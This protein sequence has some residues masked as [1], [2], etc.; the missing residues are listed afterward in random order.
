MGRP[1]QPDQRTTVKT[2][3]IDRAK[4]ITKPFAGDDH[5]DTWAARMLA[6]A[7]EFQTNRR[8][9]PLGSMF[10]TNSR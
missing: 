9:D 6:A 2:L 8:P 4:Q 3:P 10:V 7:D 5:L 1:G